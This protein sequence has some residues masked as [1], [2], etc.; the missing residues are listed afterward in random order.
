M[1]GGKGRA[2]GGGRAP[3]C[4]AGNW[5]CRR[6]QSCSGGTGWGGLLNS[7]RVWGR[8]LCAST[9]TLT[10]SPLPSEPCGFEA[11]YQELA[12]AVRDEYPDIE[13]ESRLGGTGETPQQL[14]GWGGHPRPPPPPCWGFWGEAGVG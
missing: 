3:E 8:G 9:P 4:G 11:T 7:G 1:L 14:W 6:Q 13:I 10:G 2:G 12:S 5:G